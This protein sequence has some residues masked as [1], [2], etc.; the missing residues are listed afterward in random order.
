M[1]GDAKF[2]EWQEYQ[3][4]AGVRWEADRAR[5]SLANAGVPLDENLT[6]PLLK[7]LQTAE[8]AAADGVGSWRPQPTAW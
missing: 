7:T 4:M 6:K 1:L 8:D 3:S 5:S 2:R